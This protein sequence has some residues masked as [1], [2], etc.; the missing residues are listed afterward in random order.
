MNVH[1]EAEILLNDA[2]ERGA[3]SFGNVILPP[4]LE[5]F[6]LYAG[7]ISRAMDLAKVVQTEERDLKIIASHHEIE[8][9][10]INTAF[11]EVEAAMISDFKTEEDK[12]AGTFQAIEQ[13]IAAGQYELAS[14]FHKRLIEGQKRTVLETLLDARNAAVGGGV[15]RLRVL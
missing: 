9:A 8:I 1:T 14:E 11:R 5:K 4:G 6:T 10:R 3:Q 15:G 2:R 12:R 13:L 7:L